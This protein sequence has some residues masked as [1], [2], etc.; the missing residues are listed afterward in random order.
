MKNIFK[1]HNLINEIETFNTVERVMHGVISFNELKKLTGCNDELLNRILN[2]LAN[3][4]KIY[5][6]RRLV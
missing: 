6:L 4:G 3:E 1:R 5:D 2:Q